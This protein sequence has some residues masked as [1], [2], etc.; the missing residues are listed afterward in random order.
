MLTFPAEHEPV[1]SQDL[2]AIARTLA[3]LV[4]EG[5]RRALLVQKVDGYRMTICSG[6]VIM[7]DGVET[8]ARPG[9]LVRGPQVAAELRATA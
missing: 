9:R 8:G 7:E 3:R 2:A 4:D 6:E 5:G 1:R